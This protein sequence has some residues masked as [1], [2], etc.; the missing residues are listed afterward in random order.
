MDQTVLNKIEIIQTI[1]ECIYFD[2]VVEFNDYYNDN[3]DVLDKTTTHKLNKMISIPDY[4]IGCI[5]GVLIVKKE[6]NNTINRRLEHLETII[7]EYEV[8]IN[9]L[10]TSYNAISDILQEK[11]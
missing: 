3:K 11:C 1:S 4:K 2:N 7:E 5:K 10:I 9:S 6:S 8:K